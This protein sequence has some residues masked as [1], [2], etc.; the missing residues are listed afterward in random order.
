MCLSRHFLYLS[1][2]GWSSLSCHLESLP[3]DASGG[4][5]KLI[6]LTWRCN[7]TTSLS[8]EGS[9][10]L[11]LRTTK[12]KITGACSV[13]D[14]HRLILCRS[15]GLQAIS[16]PPP[17]SAAFQNFYLEEHYPS[18]VDFDDACMDIL[19]QPAPVDWSKCPILL[20]V[21]DYSPSIPVGQAR[22]LYIQVEE[23]LV[24]LSDGTNKSDIKSLQ[25]EQATSGP[26]LPLKRH[27]CHQVVFYHEMLP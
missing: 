19:L 8:L 12:L 11:T 13:F 14:V 23:R 1:P 25:K 3:T 20:R 5:I 2:A 18:I 15:D 16:T 27:L 4:F 7:P 17:T 22:P 26:G 24:G 6:Q 9:S 21:L 10:G